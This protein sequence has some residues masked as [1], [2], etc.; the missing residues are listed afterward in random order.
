[1]QDGSSST[2]PATSHTVNTSEQL[3]EVS[4]TLSN[5]VM[6]A[7]LNSYIYVV[8]LLMHCTQHSSG[9]TSPTLASQYDIVTSTAS[10]LPLLDVS[11]NS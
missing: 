3:S 7:H 11:F 9:S 1:M 2:L 4:S 5:L 8:S 10:R 6:P